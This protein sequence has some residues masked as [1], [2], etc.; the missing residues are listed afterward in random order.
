MQVEMPVDKAISTLLRLGLATETP[1]D[2]RTRLQAV[3]CAE[4]YEALKTRWNSL[5]SWDACEALKTRWDSLLSW[6]GN[7]CTGFLLHYIR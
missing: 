2:G 4:A 5:L 1:I 7:T 6:D 3:P